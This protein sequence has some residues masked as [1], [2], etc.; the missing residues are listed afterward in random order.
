MHQAN[1][2][3]S[4]VSNARRDGKRD[5]DVSIASLTEAKPSI[6]NPLHSTLAASLSDSGNAS[7][8]VRP[9]SAAVAAEP[10]PIAG[11]AA[12]I[13]NLLVAEGR[14]AISIV[15]AMGIYHYLSPR[16]L[17]IAGKPAEYF[18]GRGLEVTMD[19]TA[20]AERLS[21][22]RQAMTAAK[23]VL[24]VESLAGVPLRTIIHRAAAP[25]GE[26]LALCV[27]HIGA[28]AMELPLDPERYTIITPVN[29]EITP[30]SKLTAREIEVLRMIAMGD[31][32]AEIAA[33]IHRTVKTVEWHRASLGRKLGATSRVELARLAIRYGLV[34][35]EFAASHEGSVATA[36]GPTDHGTPPE[37]PD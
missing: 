1:S 6:A 30:L 10:L 13:W 36:P 29:H 9:T 21:L 37:Q 15:D 5:A 23:P 18:L 27:H 20:G 3:N 28:A 14:L 31:S 12:A 2:H 22:V 7:A 25:S 35:T 4:D 34:T 17:E 24:L 33:K 19:S 32:Q 11:D 26:L 16:L 8:G